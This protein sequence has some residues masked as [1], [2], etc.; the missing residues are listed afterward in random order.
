MNITLLTNSEF[1]AGIT[2]ISNNVSAGYLLPAIREAQDIRLRGI[3]GKRLTDKLIEL[4]EN[5]QVNAQGNEYY[6]EL[7]DKCQYLLAYQAAVGIIEKSAYKI[8]NFGVMRSHDERAEQS[9]RD[10]IIL[11]KSEYQS[12]ADYYAH[13]LQC[14]LLDNRS[15]FPELS[16]YTCRC[17][18]SNLTSSATCGIFLGGARGK[19]I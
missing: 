2:G 19:K 12:K 5:E 7:L 13:H 16:E 4:V 11:R 6:A 3:L 14:Y 10:E 8:G 9:S 1:V 18:R 15:E 17:L